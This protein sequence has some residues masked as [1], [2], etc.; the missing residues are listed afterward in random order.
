[1][2]PCYLVLGFATVVLGD[3][4]EQDIFEEFPNT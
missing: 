4:R 2:S 3:V 1:M